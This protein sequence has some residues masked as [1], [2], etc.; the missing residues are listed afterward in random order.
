MERVQCACGAVGHVVHPHRAP[1]D[2]REGPELVWRGG[3]IDLCRMAVEQ[4]GEGKRSCPACRR[5]PCVYLQM[6]PMAS[7]H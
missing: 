7:P 4:A 5:R 2:K 3:R 6:S 1:G